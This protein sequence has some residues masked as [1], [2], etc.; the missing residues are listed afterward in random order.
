MIEVKILIDNIN[1]ESVAEFL[2]PLLAESMKKGEKGGILGSVLAGNP[3]MATNMARTILKTMSQEKKDELLLQM[4]A[5]HR[6]KILSGA[7]NALGKKGIG[8]E[9]CDIAARKV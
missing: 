1:Y 6:D 7:R 9:L 3:D 2:V 5:K 8:V 4:L